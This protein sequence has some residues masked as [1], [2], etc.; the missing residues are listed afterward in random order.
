MLKKLCKLHTDLS[1]EDIAQ[2]ENIEKSIPM[3]ANLVKGDIFI[4]CLT[5]DHDVAI[6]VS[7]AKP[8]NCK[9][10][11]KSYVVGKIALRQ[12]EPAALRTLEIGMETT[13]LK[14]IT[15]ENIVVKQNTVPIKNRDDKIIG[16]LIME[17]DIT[18]DVTQSR[19]VEILSQTTEQLSETLMNIKDSDY[20]NAVAYN[21]INDGILAINELGVCIYVN[22]KA[23]EL[24]RK[25]G[26]K[27]KLVG[28]SFDN[29]VLNEVNFHDMMKEK[30][31]IVLEA[32]VGKFVLQTKYAVIKKLNNVY[33]IIM[34]I[35]DLT[36]IKEKEKEL[37]LK[38][39]AIRE[40]H[41]RVKN[42]LQTIA[43]ILRLQSRRIDNAEAK[44]AFDESINRI[45][46]IATT[47]EVLSQKGIDDADIKT[48][49]SKIKDNAI[50]N[51]IQCNKKISIE[52]G[53]DNLKI[54]SDKATSIAIV[55]NEFIEN[56]LKHAFDDKD[57]GDIQITINT[58]QTYSSISVS[59]SGRGFD[60]KLLENETL[61]LNIVRSIVK[62]KLNGNINI[63]SNENGTKS[64]FYFKN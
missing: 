62:D 10:L 11:Y 61:G 23:E 63:Q 16:V 57:E 47:H 48:I 2:L 27:D 50:R 34:L 60:M 51:S 5:R 42:N 33:G 28:M 38:A 58:G 53:G 3:F 55:V 24:Y 44:R 12:N 15:Q 21:L 20:E 31:S 4:D 8:T 39:V 37:I 26:Y 35:K 9:S 45:L 54:N 13:D 18:E 36:D 30:K 43:S 46:S 22:Y 32:N 49:L 29:L 6:V 19:N 1:K 59:D 7:E 56:S 64:V 25:I 40:I 17:K 41:H 14:A 52:L